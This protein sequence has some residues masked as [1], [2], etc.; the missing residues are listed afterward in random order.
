MTVIK[1]QFHFVKLAQKFLVAHY[2]PLTSICGKI[3]DNFIIN[4]HYL[5][6]LCSELNVK[7]QNV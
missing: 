4:S 6:V 2:E 1:T 7:V 5:Q 3:F